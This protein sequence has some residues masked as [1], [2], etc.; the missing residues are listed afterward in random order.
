MSRRIKI[1]AHKHA[2]AHV[3]QRCRRASFTCKVAYNS[4]GHFASIRR[5]S[6]IRKVAYHPAGNS[7]STWRAH[8][9]C[10]VAD[11]L[12]RHWRRTRRVNLPSRRI[13]LL[14]SKTLPP[15]SRRSAR[16]GIT[17][18]ALPALPALPVLPAI[19]L[20]GMQTLRTLGAD[21]LLIKWRPTLVAT[22]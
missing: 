17:E 6:F 18:P 12:G 5:A 7:A 2:D 13:G 9:N 19:S 22:W 20:S 3:Y 15:I 8:F 16:D 10:K 21:V 14:D 1:Q 4:V 11:R